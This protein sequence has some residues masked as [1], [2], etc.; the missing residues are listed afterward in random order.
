M[1]TVSE[2]AV[3]KPPKWSLHGEGKVFIVNKR[4]KKNIQRHLEE[5]RAERE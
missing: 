2:D 5:P 4:E 1:S 3:R